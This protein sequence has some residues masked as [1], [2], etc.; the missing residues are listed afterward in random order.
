MGASF[1]A[2]A[3]TRIHVE[4]DWKGK[5]GGIPDPRHSGVHGER[6]YVYERD[7]AENTERRLAVISENDL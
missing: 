6:R 5:A 7:L 3:P 2:R 4:K 1:C